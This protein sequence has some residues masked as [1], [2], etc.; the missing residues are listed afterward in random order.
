[1]SRG[2]P[3]RGGHHS[4][5]LFGKER[6]KEVMNLPSKKVGR[7]PGNLEE[8]QS[9][10]SRDGNISSVDY[11]VARKISTRA[12]RRQ[13]LEGASYDTFSVQYQ[14]NNFY[15]YSLAGARKHK[16]PVGQPPHKNFRPQ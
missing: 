16:C 13:K 15:L 2:R 7:L 8:F 10:P 12:R 4:S 6:D 9:M 1:M 5:D 3:V 11:C 14:K